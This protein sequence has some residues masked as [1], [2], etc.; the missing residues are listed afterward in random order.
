MSIHSKVF[1]G[2]NFEPRTLVELLRW[3]TTHFAHQRAY[4]Y[5]QDGEEKDILMTYGD[6]DRRAR[7]LG[8]W[9]QSIGATGE[10]ALLIY[11]PGIEYI[12]A[13]FGCL[14]AG[15]TAVPAYPPDPTRLNRTLPRLQAI[16]RDAQ[17]ALVLTNDSILSMIKIMRIGSKVTDSLEKVPFF[18]KFGSALGTF[19]SQRS[20][21]L[22]AK[23]LSELQ[24]LSTED[25]KNDLAEDWKEPNINKDTLAFLQYTSGSTGMPRGVMLSHENLLYNLALIYEGFAFTPD[26]EGVIWLPIYHDMGLIGGVLQPLYGGFPCTLM[27]PIDFLQRPLRWLNAISRI[28]NAQVISGGPNF[29]YDLCARKITPEQKEKL[30]LGHWKVAFSGAEP[31]RPE[32]IDRFTNTF[33]PCGF[34][35]EAFYPCYGLAEATLFVSGGN[36][37]DPPVIVTIKKSELKN[38][39][40]V[41]SLPGQNDSQLAVG[42]GHT[43]G[44]QIIAIVNPETLEECRPNEIGEIWVS[45]TSVAK[46]Y[47]NR[48]EETEETFKAQIKGKEGRYFLRTGDMGYLKGSE[49]FITGR[50]KD[51]IIIRGRNHYP[52][53]IEFTVENC[54]PDLRPGCS[55]AFSVEI[56]GQERLVIVVE[57]RN[58]KKLNAEAVIHAIRRSVTEAHELQAYA[59]VLIKPRS[60]SKTSS[61]KI[62]RRATKNEFLEGKL[63]VVAEWRASGPMQTDISV[64][65]IVAEHEHAPEPVPSSEIVPASSKLKSPTVSAIESWLV[66]K[67]AE[68]L[69]INA[70]EISIQEPFV[71]FGLDSAQAVGLVGDL[72]EWLGRKLSPTLVWDYPTIES[73]AMFL[74][75]EETG[76]VGAAKPKTIKSMD[77]EPIA[78]IGMA[79]RFP[80]AD[81]PEEFWELLVDGGDAI[82]AVP[83]DRW[84]RDAFYDS[85]PDVPGKMVIRDG[86]F[87]KQIDQFD[88]QFFGISAQEAS[89]MDPQ[90]RLLLEV[91]WE[92]LEHAGI[93]P[94]R[95]AG[96]DTGVFIG[97]SNDDYTASLYRDHSLIDAYTGTGNAFSIA[98][99]R[100]SYLLDLKGPSIALDTACSSSLSAIHLAVQSLRNGESSLAIAGGVNVIISP[101]RNISF[102]H[103]R[104]LAP[105]GRCKSFDASAD[106]YVRGEGCGVI[107]LK[108]LSDALA[109]G[110]RIL[111]LIRGSAVNHDGKTNGISAPSGRAQQAV[112]LQALANANIKPEQM[113]YIEAHG[114]GTSLGDPIE[115]EALA[116]VHRH[117]PKDQPCI[118]GCVKANIGHLE[119]A[120]GIAGVIKVVLALQNELIPKQLHF[121]RINPYFDIDNSPLR[122]ATEPIFWKAGE[123]RRIAGV[124]SFGFGGTNAHVVIEEALK[125]K[126]AID[127][128]ERSV[129]ILMLSAKTEAALNELAKRYQRYFQ[130]HPGINIGDACFS[131]NTGR[132]L[133]THRLA[134]VGNSIEEF[135]DRLAAFADGKEEIGV[136]W[137][138]VRSERRSK[139]AFLFTGQG[140]EYVG[141]GRELYQT[142]P[143]FK[144]AL[145]QCD[146]ILRSDLPVPLLSVIFSTND[147][148]AAL[149]HETQYAHISLFALQYALAQ[150]W[151]SWGIEPDYVYGHSVGEYVAACVAGFFSLEDGL[152]LVAMRARLIQSLP[153]NGEMAVIFASK[154]RIAET[155]EPYQDKVAIAAI[156]GPENIVISG[157]REAVMT[158]V[159]LLAGDGINSRHLKVSHAFHS[160]LMEPILDEFEQFASEIQHKSPRVPMIS[161]L[162]GHILGPWEIPDARYWRRHLRE[163]VQ[164]AAAMQALAD[165]RCDIFLEIGPNPIL[166]GMG[167]R[168]LPDSSAKWLPSLRENK[169]DW[170]VMLDSLAQ[171]AVTGAAIDWNSFDADYVRS[172]VSLP[173]YPFQRQRYWIE[174][175]KP[176]K[177]PILGS[178]SIQSTGPIIHPLLHSLLRSPALKD[179]VFESRLSLSNLTWLAH[180]RV[181]GMPIF[182]A[183]AYLDMALAAAQQLFGTQNYQI[184]N[185]AILEPMAFSNGEPRNV[186]MIIRSS[187]QPSKQFQ[188]YSSTLTNSGTVDS[189]KLHAIGSLLNLN[190]KPQDTQERTDLETIR[191]R[192]NEA[193]DPKSY[194]QKLQHLGLKY[195]HSFQT[196]RQLW[197][198][199]HEVLGRIELEETASADLTSHHLHPAL[200][201]GGF[202]MVGAIISE[203]EDWIYLPIGLERMQLVRKPDE[204]LWCHVLWRNSG[205]SNSE[206]IESDLNFYNDAGHLV[207]QVDGLSLKKTTLSSLASVSEARLNQWLYHIEWRKVERPKMA[208]Q[209]QSS[210]AGRWLLFITEKELTAKFV[211]ELQ[212]QIE[213]SYIVTPGDRLTKLADDR[214][215]IDPQNLADYQ[216]LIG[217]LV[218]AEGKPLQGIIYLWGL[219]ESLTGDVLSVCSSML[220]LVQALEKAKP[221]RFPQLWLITRGA[222][223]VDSTAALIDLNGSALWG[224]ARVIALEHPELKP[225]SIDLD[226]NSE[227][228]DYTALAGEIQANDAEDQVA[229]RDGNRYV[230]RLASIAQPEA[231]TERA[232]PADQPFQLTI[233]E[234]GMLDNLRFQPMT[235]QKPGPGQVEIQ[236]KAIGQNFRDV[237]NALNLYP[238]DP[239]PLGGECSGEISAIGEGV[240]GFKIG[241]AVIAIAPGCFASHVITEAN[242]VVKKP[243]H[244]SFEQA[245]TIPIAFLTAYYAL[246]K[247]GKMSAGEKV[248]IH[249]ATGG[250]GLAAIQLA[251]N[252]GAEIFTTAGNS[253]KREFLKSLGIEHVMDSRSLSFADEILKVTQG[254]GVDIVLNT[255]SGE[256]IPKGL[257]V[258][259]KQGRFLEIGK[260]G[261]W[262]PQQVKNF[263]S[264]VA[265]F[266]I[267]LDDLLYQDSRSVMLMLE[268]LMEQFN[269]GKLQPLHHHVFSMDQVVDAFRWMEQARHI[270]KVVVRQDRSFG[271]RTLVIRGDASYLITGAFGGLG[272]MI[273]RWL[274][275]HGARHLILADILQPSEA[276]EQSIAELT[277]RGA[278]VTKFIGD[279][280]QPS[281][282]EQL[283]RMLDPTQSSSL[284][285]LAGVIHLAGKLDDGVILQQDRDK[286]AQV[287]A[288]KVAGSYNLHQMTKQMALDFFVMFSSVAAI[289]G[290]PGQANYAAANAFMDGLAH[291]RRAIGLPAISINW[292]PW[293]KVGTAGQLD[294]QDRQRYESIGFDLIPPEL[295][296]K[297]LEKL[298]SQ[299]LPQIAVLPVNWSR[300]LKQFPADRV[301]GLFADFVSTGKP[302][303]P[304]TMVSQSD[305][306]ERLRR[307]APKDRKELLVGQLQKEVI[308]IL[309]LDASYPVDIRKPLKEMGFDSLMA[310]ELKNA[311]SASVK[312][313]LSVTLIFDYPTIES[314][315]DYLI[316]HI[317]EAD[318]HIKTSQPTLTRDQFESKEIE[319]LA[320]LSDAEVEAL[321]EAKLA[322]LEM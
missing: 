17:A 253:Q 13:F 64:E 28:K 159:E 12:T 162:N 164:F 282:F 280:A 148:Q 175:A 218:S 15:V 207:A 183:A 156:N 243:I 226:P 251:K 236:V 254:K 290:S 233:T 74:A 145:D 289:F 209:L 195:G 119:S 25:I 199:V 152:K 69:G 50:I 104:M 48:P 202:Q 76:D 269:L 106:G 124:S 42:C 52:Q 310:I 267:A 316:E 223:P 35:R 181:F 34:R 171:L 114:T 248:L 51:L 188:I 79:C 308:R 111:A 46:G 305:F 273:A 117:R 292:G 45:G 172:K 55:A 217:E 322:A 113:G 294:H 70:S 242:W 265:Y 234:R 193:I 101:E 166:L 150:L 84:D 108:R 262:S 5:L 18:K 105:D 136:H 278:V 81:N 312:T 182:P 89:R 149:I 44:D 211:Q 102:S 130:K 320:D 301:P 297:V 19:L 154:E 142:Q 245:A 97:I 122:I 112:I 205:T 194:Y 1:G 24:W 176:L 71:S 16:A 29:A 275:E 287:L 14:Y 239:G 222:Q 53:D 317:F 270:G 246:Q 204:R 123:G 264:D 65:T 216:Q 129:H 143:T 185:V 163:T 73:L 165:E 132:S 258:L 98:A 134:V 237:L 210:I 66:S 220:Y 147:Q 272:L 227:I 276:A 268:E 158:V 146:E 235:R 231:R 67:I 133:F 27:S 186:Q 151:R 215:Q 121:Q 61:G 100:L 309:G 298:I 140:S 197:K 77:T 180:H 4:T 302:S 168:C 261:I 178:A 213:T 60:I 274:V 78:I 256:Y 144:E 288:P 95:L 184:S 179:T 32:T 39:R 285:S 94:E 307:T 191:M 206:I 88:P 318:A 187:D 263:R 41:E 47:W 283:K 315:A 127:Q 137:G 30:S 138:V 221:R 75:A 277:E 249:T 281:A 228:I 11:P 103:A 271:E 155:V 212:S 92:A 86:G 214:W 125:P 2:V 20:A 40:F 260:I 284:P 303:S 9:L 192:C 126:A 229:L 139:I 225:I 311:I 72:E 62:Q 295:G 49:L 169:N 116:A 93:I 8:A 286:L 279:I 252:I 128:P 36:S 82:T 110:D 83:E 198:G 91:T 174:E 196:I 7:A 266:T 238:G 203:A 109:H 131:A 33:A 189:W 190:E 21:I 157:E 90:Q 23:D 240:T 244:W 306:L 22:N 241:D 319:D 167:R 58:P 230:P 115:L 31:V 85:N 160:P 135:C 68:N 321:L 208:E 99:N 153:R 141:M 200:L 259:A 247:L 107:I 314:L 63:Q 80:G 87:L 37:A 224:L 26:C 257:S 38:N 3:R 173:T 170:Q 54:H 10:R 59:I 250:V 296:L 219:P 293:A 161:N 6:L 201:D 313:D 232:V 57:V 118:I 43:Y 120:A 56:E 255:L 300:F 304:E 96:S 299:P 177:A 291:H